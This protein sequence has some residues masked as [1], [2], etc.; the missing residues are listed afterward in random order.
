MHTGPWDHYIYIY[1]YML[2]LMIYWQFN[3]GKRKS[4]QY[5]YCDCDRVKLPDTRPY[6]S[7]KKKMFY[8]HTLLNFHTVLSIRPYRTA[9]N[10]IA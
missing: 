9:G 2:L 4:L 5:T 6:L 8:P 7:G 3:E 1:I 10:P